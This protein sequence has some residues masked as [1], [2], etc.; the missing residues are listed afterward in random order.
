M[1]VHAVEKEPLPPLE[2]SMPRDEGGR[3]TQKDKAGMISAVQIMINPHT[4]LRS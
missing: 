1:K 3:R 2:H 4:V